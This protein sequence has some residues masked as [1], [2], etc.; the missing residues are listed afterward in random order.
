MARRP[1][2]A[3]TPLPLMSWLVSEAVP[4][5]PV[6]QGQPKRG[7]PYSTPA[8]QFL[9]G[10][11]F[12]LHCWFSLSRLVGWHL[13]KLLTLHSESVPILQAKQPWTAATFAGLTPGSSLEAL[14]NPTRGHRFSGQVI[15]HPSKVL[16]HLT[17]PKPPVNRW[18]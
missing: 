18:A 16:A 13:S 2:R 9:C 5:V 14:I 7:K 8:L 11:L 10:H 1:P 12:G 3:E 17:V 15:P 6:P 4:D